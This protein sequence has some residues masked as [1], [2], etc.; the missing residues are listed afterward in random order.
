[1]TANAVRSFVKMPDIS[2]GGISLIEIEQQIIQIIFIEFRGAPAAW[3]LETAASPDFK[4]P[5]SS[6]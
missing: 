6:G 5:A 3:R 2:V 1:M 4:W